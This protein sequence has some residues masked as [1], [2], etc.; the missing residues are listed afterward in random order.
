MNTK[1]RSLVW[2]VL[3]VVTIFTLS[4]AS[5]IAVPEIG[6]QFSRDKVAHF[7]VFGLLATS[8]LRIPYFNNRGWRGAAAAA[9]ITICFGGFDELRQS[10]TPGRSVEFADWLADSS[11][12]IV[13]VVAYRY[14]SPYRR[15]LEWSLF[16]K[17]KR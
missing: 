7:L 5:R 4:G 15:I 9:I 2:P 3:L 13:A 14:L 11:G 17:R 6:L 8:L 12:A 10:F 1:K 16:S